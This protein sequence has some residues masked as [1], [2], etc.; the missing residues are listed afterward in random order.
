MW[1]FFLFFCSL[2][3]TIFKFFVFK[4]L[5]QEEDKPKFTP[6]TSVICQQFA[7][8]ISGESASNSAIN[9]FMSFKKFNS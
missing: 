4:G 5:L 9:A 2:V 8:L 1:F 3:F 7:R 6:S